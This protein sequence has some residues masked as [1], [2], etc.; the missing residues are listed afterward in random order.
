MKGRERLK[1]KSKLGC[2]LAVTVSSEELSIIERRMQ[3]LGCTSLA[4][5]QRKAIE[6]YAGEKIFRKRVYDKKVLY[7]EKSGR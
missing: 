4:D 7:P 5:F 3:E 1:P 6:H 2:K